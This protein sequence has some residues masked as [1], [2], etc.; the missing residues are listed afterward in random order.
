MRVVNIRE[1]TAYVAPGGRLTKVLADEAAGANNVLVCHAELPPG[2]QSDVHAREEEEIIY[3][4]EGEQVIRTPAGEEYRLGPGCLLFIPP[5]TVHQH[6]NPG[7]E[8]VR[9]LG[10]F[11][12]PAGLGRAIRKRPAA[13]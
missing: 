5:G 9:F 10:I 12:P 6:T 8:S 7:G 2:A 13:R 3:V 1:E 4:L 11:S